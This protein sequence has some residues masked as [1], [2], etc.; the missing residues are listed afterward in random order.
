M[1]GLAGLLGCPQQPT[2]DPTN[3]P[4][5]REREQA[6]KSDGDPRVDPARCSGDD[7]ELA[8]LVG[9]GP[10]TIPVADAIALPSPERLELIA[11]EQLVVAPGERLEFAL[12]LRNRSKHPLDVDL[13]FRRFLPLA[14]ESTQTLEGHSVPD[15]S[16]TLRAMSTEPPPERFTLPPEAELA[17]PCELYANTRLVNPDS[18]V[19]SECPDFPE[20]APGRYRSVFQINGASGSQREVVVEIEVRAR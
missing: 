14:P 19:A 12:V 2:L 10:C 8:V 9:T 11:P 13:R 17:I 15:D 4:R 18:Y 6:R 16:C 20:L 1:C 5:Q 3:R 7:L